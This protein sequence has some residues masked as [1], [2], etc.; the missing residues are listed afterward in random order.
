MIVSVLA[1]LA[2]CA[3]CK[4]FTMGGKNKYAPD[5]SGKV[6]IVTGSNTGIGFTAALELAKL[7]PKTIIMACR[8]QT[9]ALAAIATIES[10][11]TL[12]SS[13]KTQLEFVK[14]DLSDL[15]S[16]KEFAEEIKSKYSKIDMLVNN[17]GMLV[18]Q[19]DFTAQNHELM[20]GVNHL[21]HFLLTKLLLEQLKASDEARIINLSSDAHKMCKG[22]IDL[23][24][25]NSDKNFK[26]FPTYAMT[27][28][29]NI[30]YTK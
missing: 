6:I 22:S 10:K 18:Q 28:F 8:S 3:L 19:K 2:V 27:K 11:L 14:L 25:L 23:D 4:C 9:R 21:G 1:V 12:P 7:G 15:N 5:L 20:F 24:D 30:L 26:G 29:C 13:N 16:V 17:A